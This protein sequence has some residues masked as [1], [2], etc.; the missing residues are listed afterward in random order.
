MAKLK[1]QSDLQR[2]AGIL[3]IKVILIREVN[4]AKCIEVVMK[5]EGEGEQ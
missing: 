4:M 5:G 3:A 2:A 1:L